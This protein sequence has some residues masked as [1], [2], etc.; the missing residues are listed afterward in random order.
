M[1]TKAMDFINNDGIL[2]VL[3][4]RHC[5]SSVSLIFP[6][7]QREISAHVTL[8]LRNGGRYWPPGALPRYGGLSIVPDEVN[9][10]C[11]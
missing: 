9:L 11:T 7:E 1:D 10:Q 5:N 8:T 6:K 3:L 4:R 2:T